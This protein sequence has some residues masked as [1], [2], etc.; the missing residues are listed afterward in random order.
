MIRVFKSGAHSNRTPLSYPALLPLFEGDLTLVD[1]P[2]QADLYV[3]AHSLDIFD[4]PRDLIDDWRR[5]QCP[6][7]LL[8]EEP[9]WETIWARQPLAKYRLLASRWGPLPVHQ[10]THQTSDVFRFDRIPYYLLTNHRFA[11]AYAARFSRNAAL[12]PA[13]WAERLRVAASDLTFVFERRP[14]PHHS[15]TWLEGDLIGLCAWRTEVAETTCRGRIKRLGHSWAADM[16]ARQMLHDWHL[17]KLTTLDGQTRVMAAF[18]NT[19][20][21]QYIT[22]KIFDAFACGAVPAYF[23][24]PRHRIHD[25]ELPSESW[26]NL[27]G[28]KPEVAAERL[29][30]I[31]WADPIFLRTTCT[32]YA[33]AQRGLAELFTSVTIW[34]KERSRLAKALPAALAQILDVDHYQLPAPAGEV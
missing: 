12:S 8:S 7:V 17:D 1:S 31:D 27:A 34:Q 18:E 23:A 10:V 13:E 2:E 6:I 24:T 32:A 16:P 26:I 25:F 19:H 29:D 9:F 14:E 22:E 30:Q 11:Y 4:A 15:L 5:R 3:F 21:P 33:E 20:Q 28:F